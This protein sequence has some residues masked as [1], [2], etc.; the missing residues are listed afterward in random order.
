MANEARRNRAS[1]AL[2]APLLPL[3]GLPRPSPPRPQPRPDPLRQLLPSRRP[4]PGPALPLPR[5]RPDL[6]PADLLLHLLPQ[7]PR[8]ALGRRGRPPGRL[9]PPPAG[10][11]PALRQDLRHP[12]GPT[13]RHPRR[14]A[15]GPARGRTSPPLRSRRPRPLRELRRLPAAGAGARHRRRRPLALR[16]RARPGPASRLRPAARPARRLRPSLGREQ[17]LRPQHPALARPAAAAGAG[18]SATRARR[19]RPQRLPDGPEGPPR[20]RA[21][22]ARCPPQPGPWSEGQP[23]LEGGDRA[24]PRDGPGR[25]VAPTAA[26]HLRRAQARDDRLRA[27]PAGGAGPGL[28]DDRLEEPGQGPLRA[29][30]RPDDPGD[31]AG[32]DCRAVALGAGPGPAAL[33]GARGVTRLVA[34]AARTSTS[35]RRPAPRQRPRPRPHFRLRPAAPTGLRPPWG[36]SGSISPL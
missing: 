23:A 29:A 10:A 6:L 30:T 21:D 7:A 4:P 8:A 16:L 34:P 18:R 36:F 26:P 22:P 20:G 28:P 33:P 24:G 31:G 13:P 19:R 15:P 14:P 2:P 32:T 11:L 12:A 1:R 5:L 3:A 9:R 27:R 17:R 35:T 25:P